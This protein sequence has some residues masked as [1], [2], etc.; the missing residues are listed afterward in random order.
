MADIKRLLL[1]QFF[2]GKLE[3]LFPLFCTENIL[4]LHRMWTNKHA[5]EPTNGNIHR[6]LGRDAKT[7]FETRKK[8]ILQKITNFSSSWREKTP[9]SHLQKK[10]LRMCVH[11]TIA[12]KY[13]NLTDWLRRK[14]LTIHSP[15][16]INVRRFLTSAKKT[17]PVKMMPTKAG[18]TFL[19]KPGV[20]IKLLLLILEIKL[21]KAYVPVTVSHLLCMSPQHRM[22]LL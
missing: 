17:C 14:K 10:G 13:N 11:P 18:V 2:W 21:V 12:S 4:I 5:P 9:L 19:M 6:V 8:A 16:H 7:I 3:I 20:N 15:H 22:H 1:A